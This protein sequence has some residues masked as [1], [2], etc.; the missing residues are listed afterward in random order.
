MLMSHPSLRIRWL[1]LLSLVGLTLILALQPTDAV[2]VEAF[3]QAA[4]LA[5]PNVGGAKVGEDTGQSAHM[6][7][8]DIEAAFQRAAARRPFDP[9]PWRRLGDL[10]TTWG[11]AQDAAHAYGRALLRGDNTSALY[12]SSAQ[13]FATL[14]DIR[15]AAYHWSEYLE[16]RPDDRATRLVLALTSIR[17]A[18]WERARAELEHLLADDPSDTLI[19]AWL[20]LLLVGPDPTASLHHL[21]SAAHDPTLADILAR[22]FAAGRLSTAV[23]DPAYRSALLGVSLLDLDVSTLHRL[24]KLGGYDRGTE[25]A[26]QKAAT[27]LALRS[28]LAAVIRNPAYAEA[29]AYLGQALDHLG[30]SDWAQASLQYALQLAPES[31]VAQTLMGLYW[32]RHGSPALAREYYEAAHRQDQ[33]NA[34]LYLEIA[35]TYLAEGE[36]TAA[37]VWFLYAADIAPNDP[38]VWETLAHYYLDLGIDIAESG[39]AAARRLLELAPDDAR[40]H[41]LMGW[42]FFLI[43]DDAQAKDS[44]DQALARDPG[45]ASVH[46]HLGRLQARQGRYAEASQSYRQ[47]ADYDVRGQLAAQLERAWADLPSTYQDE[48]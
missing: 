48:P 19:H 34:S 29:Y 31:L 12:Q 18:D 41:D 44:L 1:I 21:Q 5:T 33:D 7:R 11:R 13:L 43:S 15:L 8:R 22:V 16:R 30:W 42:A 32:D 45:L 10:Y 38:R 40:A 9:Q 39:L 36:Y 46:Y 26:L 37:E 25:D 20:G 28:L 17:L 14:G 2:A 4:Q 47:A 3:Q 23:D 6:S 27:T 35:A 24:A